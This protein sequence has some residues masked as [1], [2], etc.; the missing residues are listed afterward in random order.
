MG[1]KR[2]TYEIKIV[3]GVWYKSRIYVRP[4]SAQFECG[5]VIILA[6]IDAAPLGTGN[7]VQRDVRLACLQLPT[8]RIEK[9]QGPASVV[10]SGAAFKYLQVPQWRPSCDNRQIGRLR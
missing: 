4:K 9:T 3:E 7:L 6:E 2:C 5:G 1:R 10:S 8:R